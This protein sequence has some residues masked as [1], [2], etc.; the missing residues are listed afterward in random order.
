[1]N[2]YGRDADSVIAYAIHGIQPL[3]RTAIREA[4][5]RQK[6]L[7]KPMGSLGQLED[8]AI[9]I[10]GITG[11]VRNTLEHKKIFLFG[12]DNGVYEEGI[13]GSPQALTG[14][15]MEL[16]A[17]KGGGCID[18]LCEKTGVRLSLFDLG[19]KGLA[20]RKG[21][22]SSHKLMPNGT[23]NI[24]HG[25][26]VPLPVT[27]ETIA[28]GIDLV[29]EAV[30]CGIQVVGTGEVGMG[31]TTTATACIMACVGSRDPGLVGRGGGLTDEG[32]KRK[33]KVILEALDFHHLTKDSSPVEIL[34]CVGGLDIAAMCGVFLGAAL[35]RIPAVVDGVIS[36]AAALLAVRLAP[37][38]QGYLFLSHA[39]KEPA[40]RAAAKELDLQPVLQLDMRLGEGSGCPLAMELL[41]DALYLMNHMAVF[42]ETT[43]DEGYREGLRF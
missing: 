17:N 22:D 41:E 11:V 18:T 21:I 19:V 35:Y 43:M 15:L 7:V 1:M 29:R 23:G 32:F 28:L 13:S 34:S 39:S 10:S 31:N 6:N 4:E 16:Y 40:Y 2:D 14:S 30:E 5:D 3:D 42:S 27:R 9:R 20:P 36:I 33:K 24:L 25:R 12:A 8:M 37:F 38:T 26:A